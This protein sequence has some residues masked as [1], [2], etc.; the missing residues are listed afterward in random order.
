[1]RIGERS[2]VIVS[3]NYGLCPS[4]IE[5]HLRVINGNGYEFHRVTSWDDVV[6]I[7]VFKNDGVD[8]VHSLVG[9]GSLV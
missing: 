8:P 9:V 2:G 6:S 1:M 7:Q 3:D 5:I 4:R